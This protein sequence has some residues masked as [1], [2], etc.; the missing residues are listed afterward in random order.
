MADEFGGRGSGR[1][2]TSG[3]ETQSRAR[4]TARGR[5][6]Q[7]RRGASKSEVS[8]RNLICSR[9]MFST[10]GIPYPTSRL[11]GPVR[12]FLNQL[13]PRERFEP[14]SNVETG[15]VVSARRSVVSACLVWST[16]SCRSC[17]QKEMRVLSE[18]S[19]REALA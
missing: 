15:C 6:A 8:E 3:D 13:E 19:S 10:W 14:S 17:P 7:V 16:I 12:L 11:V 9:K 1:R 4:L 18:S 2:K 5:R